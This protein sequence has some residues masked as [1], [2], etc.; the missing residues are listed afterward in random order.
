MRAMPIRYVADIEAA[1]RFYE[2]LGM[3]P[4]PPW[5]CAA[6]CADRACPWRRPRLGPARSG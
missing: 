6:A 3:K 2:T 5:P 4:R 1:R